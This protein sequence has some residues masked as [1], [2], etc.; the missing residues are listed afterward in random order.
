V[1]RDMTRED[2][3]DGNR[4]AAIFVAEKPIHPEAK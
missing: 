2:V 1:T 4:R 3:A